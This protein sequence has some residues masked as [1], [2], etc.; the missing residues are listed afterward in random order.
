MW[1]FRVPPSLQRRSSEPNSQQQS[2][3]APRAPD[4]LRISKL[5]F[6]WHIGKVIWSQALNIL[7]TTA[8]EDDLRDEWTPTFQTVSEVARWRCL[9]HLLVSRHVVWSELI[10]T[11]LIKELSWTT[12]FH[13]T[14]VTLGLND[15]VTGQILTCQGP[16]RPQFLRTEMLTDFAKICSERL[17]RVYQSVQGCHLCGWQIK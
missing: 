15:R 13:H 7:K 2:N 17:E 5:C 6:G 16:S 4:P 14:F 1:N 11:A 10:I 12:H 8:D 3:W 9:T